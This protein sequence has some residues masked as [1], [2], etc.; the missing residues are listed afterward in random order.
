MAEE[1]LL[2]DMDSS[3]DLTSNLERAASKSLTAKLWI[4]CLLTLRTEK[5]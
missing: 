5:H 4:N 2:N 1:I 3:E